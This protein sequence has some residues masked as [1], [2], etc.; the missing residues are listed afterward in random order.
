MYD[1]KFITEL[2]RIKDVMGI[3]PPL[4]VEEGIWGKILGAVDDFISVAPKKVISTT[5]EIT[6][7]GVTIPKRVFQ[8]L[9][10]IIADP[11]LVGAL[12]ASSMKLI[13]KVLA[14]NE[15]IVNI[16]YKDSIQS[17]LTKTN[18][19]T[20]RDFL[21]IL[22]NEMEKSG[23]NLRE[24]LS[25][26]SP[27]EISNEI[28]IK[29]FRNKLKDIDE[30]TFTNEISPKPI[31]RVSKTLSSTE[32]KNFNKAIDSKGVKMFFKD[33]TD[34]WKLDLD[35]L[36]SQ[37]V[38]YSNGFVRELEGKTEEEVKQLINAYS[39]KITRLINMSEIKMNGAAA[40][41][42]GNL[43]VEP[44]LVNRIRNGTEPFFKVYREARGESDQSVLQVLWQTGQEFIVEL[45][46]LISG[47]FSRDIGKTILRMFNPRYSLGQYMISNQWASWN[48]LWRLAIKMSP[49]ESKTKMIKYLTATI[50][51]S[52]FGFLMGELIRDVTGG[53][54]DVLGK[55]NWN[56]ILKA[57]AGEDGKVLNLDVEK[58]MAELPKSMDG[59]NTNPIT[60]IA[61]AITERGW[62]SIVESFN[63]NGYLD[64]ML[65]AVPGG[66]FTFPES[67]VAKFI[68]WFTPGADI[69]DIRTNVVNF[70]K[71]SVFG[72]DETISME[73]MEA[74]IR[75]EI[76]AEN[77]DNSTT[78]TTQSQYTLDGA[79]SVASEH[80]KTLLW[81][82]PSD[83]KI[84][85]AGLNNTD[86]I[87]TLENGIYMV[88]LPL[89][90]G[91][92]KLSE[93]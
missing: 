15:E 4:L 78:D 48:K 82:Q 44:K 3:K 70:I 62:N 69:L 66:I 18:G 27:D 68:S 52:S 14:Q 11:S 91:K 43:G 26:M 74:Q 29:K 20:E 31:T 6:V 8:D 16:A 41:V 7:A 2:N 92:I 89:P 49:G 53:V 83:N 75:A 55:G 71:G 77:E 59:S 57:A 73:E 17:F 76:D 19:G 5:D 54:Y 87:V 35:K 38:E 47:I 85:V 88:T 63:E 30:G 81:Q 33:V 13:G 9:K 50:F 61:P 28:L 42:L 79:K 72:V 25:D 12:D 90:D 39:V 34:L 24:T 46:G 56:R 84:Y 80:A 93:Y 40:D 65:R 37:A 32:I 51:A 36:K 23:K 58:Y 10:D 22:S 1:K 86:Y 45:G 21:E 60:K 64:I 67:I